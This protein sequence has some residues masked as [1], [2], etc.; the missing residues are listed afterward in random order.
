[1]T[2]VADI[3]NSSQ[4]PQ[5]VQPWRVWMFGAS[6]HDGGKCWE[7]GAVYIYS[8]PPEPPAGAHMRNLRTVPTAEIACSQRADG[9]KIKYEYEIGSLDPLI[10]WRGNELDAAG[11]VV[12]TKRY[13]STRAV[14]RAIFRYDRG[15]DLEG[16]DLCPAVNFW[17]G[18]GYY[19][20]S[21]EEELLFCIQG[22]A[23]LDAVAQHYGLPAPYGEAQRQILDTKPLLY[24]ARHYDLLQLGPD[25][26][27]PVIVGGVVFRGGV[28]VRLLLYT[29]MREWEFSEPITL[30][31]LE[32]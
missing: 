10:F 2:T 3:V 9:T 25:N 31:E 14:R 12:R 27:V 11:N 24:R 8:N 20:D 28:P 30:P 4:T 29:F 18:R 5:T 16:R 22:R 23:M 6:F 21:D 19:D 26:A 1:M 17:V 13:E 32:A 15:T 7:R